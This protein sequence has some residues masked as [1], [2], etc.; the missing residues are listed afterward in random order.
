MTEESAA[1]AGSELS[2]PATYTNHLAIVY[3]IMVQQVCDLTDIEEQLC[4]LVT[5]GEQVFS[6]VI[7]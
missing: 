5:V 6:N 2:L 7:M 3:A 4:D 1:A